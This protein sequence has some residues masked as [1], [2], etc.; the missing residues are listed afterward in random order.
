MTMLPKTIP[1]LD[2]TAPLNGSEALTIIA[3]GVLVLT[4]IVIALSIGV[5]THHIITDRQRRRNRERFEA[6]TLLLAPHLVSGDGIA[7]A[8]S[9]ARR[10]HGDRAVALVLRRA[11]YDIKGE[12]TEE[13]S[14][15]LVQMG[16]VR[17]LISQ[18]KSRRDWKRA[19]AVRGLGECGGEEARMILIEASK[20]P[21]GE[22]RRAAREGL[23][24]DG[25]EDAIHA[26]IESFLE[27]LPRR[28]GWRRSF[29]ARL[30]AVAAEKL[31][32]LIES[33]RL[34]STEEKLAFEALGD[35][36]YRRTL[37][38]AVQRMSSDEAEMRA[39]A[40]RVIGKLGGDPE[41]PLVLE[42]LND[43]E[44]FVRAAAARS[45]EWLLMT[46]D[47]MKR[48]AWERMVCERLGGKL[49]DSSWWVRANSARALSRAG[50]TGVDTLLAI[51]ESQDA[52]ARDAAVAALAMAPLG[53]EA[54]LNIREKIE[55]FV[56]VAKVSEPSRSTQAGGLFA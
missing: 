12:I 48:S 43:P 32:S 33:N 36:G 2:L 54:R 35:A 45:L 19:V 9:H 47:L 25:S 50:T 44:W 1:K 6:S 52:Y 34:N 7:E 20:D 5:F 41:L 27:D 56:E 4:G 11:R 18:S 21:S 10:T 16:E 55:R 28:A 24:S 3:I 46:A 17:K 51:T 23:L 31:Q 30:A 13:I 42:A 8:V 38:L 49:S 40:V 26:A 37:P 15:M 22:V 14:R 29:Y 53:T 39:T